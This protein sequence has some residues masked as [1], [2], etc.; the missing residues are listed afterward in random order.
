MHQSQDSKLTL[1]SFS[2]KK[3]QAD[4]KSK[5]TSTHTL[6]HRIVRLAEK[7]SRKHLEE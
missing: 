4:S 1:D 6:G 7:L 3:I 2:I 5:H